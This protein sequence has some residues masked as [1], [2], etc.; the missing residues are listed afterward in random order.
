M[1]ANIL[2]PYRQEDDNRNAFAFAV[3]MARRSRTDILALTSMEPH[4]KYNPEKHQNKHT[5]LSRKDEIYCD[6][7]RMKGYYHGRFNQWNVFNEV[8][9][10]VQLVERDLNGA[11]CSAI[12][13]HSDLV[14]VLQHKAFSGTGLY[15]EILAGAADCNV[16]FFLLPAD[17]EFSEPFPNLIRIMFY[18]QKR[19]SFMKLLQ[20]TKIFDLPEEMDEFHNE[21][22][23]QQAV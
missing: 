4:S 5:W 14:I 8:N 12:N 22:I 6:L 1:K 19:A 13:D 10:H 20:A 17:G 9:I 7:L 2:F 21:L 18:Q 11:I 16:S 15:E 23:L 3:E